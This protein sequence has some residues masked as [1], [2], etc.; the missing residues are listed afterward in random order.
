MK[1]NKLEKIILEI[2]RELY[3][4]SEPKADFDELMKTDQRDSIGR[5]LIKFEDY[6][7]D[8]TDYDNIVKIIL[9]KYKLQDYEKNMIKNT[10]VLGCSPCFK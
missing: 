8:Q 5:I 3:K 9:S 2:Y 10:V 6:K 1:T 4:N 7:I